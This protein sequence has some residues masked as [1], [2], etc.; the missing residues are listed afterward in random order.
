M[1]VVIRHVGKIT[2]ELSLPLF[3]FKGGLYRFEN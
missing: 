2:R 1:S 3:I